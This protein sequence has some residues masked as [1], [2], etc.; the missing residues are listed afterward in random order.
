MLFYIIDSTLTK[1]FNPLILY[2]GIILSCV[3]P[4][5]LDTIRWY[6]IDIRNTVVF[7]LSTLYPLIQRNS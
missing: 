5:V 7:R 6:R 2:K 3:I 4:V 1:Y